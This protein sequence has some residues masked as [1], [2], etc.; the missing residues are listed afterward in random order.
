[1]GRKN[2]PPAFCTATE[3]I[4]DL[5]NHALQTSLKPKPHHLGQRAA[6]LDQYTPV[7]LDQP[8][9]G[10]FATITPDPSL[11]RPAPPTREVDV[12]VD[13]FIAIAQGSPSTLNDVRNTLLHSIDEV[14][15][16]ND[17]ADGVRA[18][19]VSLKKLDK[20]DASWKTRQTILGWDVDTEQ[21]TI[22][23]PPHRIAR[24]KELLDS[25][26]AHQRRIGVTKW[27]NMLGELRSMSIALPGS[28]GLFSHLQ[29]ALSKKHGSRVPLTAEV[30]QALADFR[31]ILNHIAE[32]P[33][34]IVELVPL[35][36]SALGYHDAS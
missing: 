20:G 35:L 24:L 27:H 5:A 25:I 11:P 9:V 14:F 2:S 32:R 18:E 3:T 13:D 36:P 12:Y 22:A 6:Q 15:R 34:R 1:M 17:E 7:A 28:R 19:P 31:W 16:P 30:H 33:T 4:A 21:K 23:L 26:P 29:A 8:D 10:P